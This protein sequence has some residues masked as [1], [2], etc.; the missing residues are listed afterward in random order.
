[1][2]NSWVLALKEYNKGR[3]YSIPKK[4]TL[5]YEKVKKI[6]LKYEKKGGSGIIKD[7]FTS[8]VD[9]VNNGIDMLL[10]QDPSSLPLMSGEHHAKK[11][12]NGKIINMNWCGPGTHVEERLARGDKGVDQI[13]EFAKNHDKTYTLVF[14]KK[15]QKGIKVSKEEVQRAD[16]EFVAGVVKNRADNPLL[17]SLIPKVFKAKKLAENTGVLSHTAFFDG[18][19]GNGLK[20]YKPPVK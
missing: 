3:I 19:T 13:D 5:E 11:I 10:P 15:L 20:V 17:A 1:M 12:V 18:N 6:Q 9:T 2:T 16:D 8:I 7:T 14:K 4:G